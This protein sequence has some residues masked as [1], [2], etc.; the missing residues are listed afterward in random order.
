M[1]SKLPCWSRAQLSYCQHGKATMCRSVLLRLLQAGRKKQL[2][3][4][5]S[6]TQPSAATAP[7]FPPSCSETRGRAHETQNTLLPTVHLTGMAH[8]QASDRQLARSSSNQTNGQHYS[9][10]RLPALYPRS[11][12]S[13]QVGGLHFHRGQLTLFLGPKYFTN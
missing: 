1:D 3:A 2:C 4:G 7:A 10:A 5:E 6:L 13:C 8:G 12:R 9:V 11:S